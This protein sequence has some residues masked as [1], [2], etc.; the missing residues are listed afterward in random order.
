MKNAIVFGA[1]SGIGKSLTEIL[2]NEG[3]QVAIT[4]RRLALLVALKNKSPNQIL[5]KQNDIQDV[6]DVEKIFHEIVTEFKTID[7]VIQSSGVG[8]IN[9]KL[10]W[11]YEEQSINTNVLGVTKLYTLAYRLF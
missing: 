1:T 4:G 9:P 11:N 5:V 8:F 10:E 6:K 2:V 7:L 3:Y